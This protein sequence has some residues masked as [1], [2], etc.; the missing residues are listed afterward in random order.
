MLLGYAAGER[1]GAWRGIEPYSEIG[2]LDAAL[3][4]PLTRLVDALDHAWR[5]LREPATVEVWCER[6]RALK[7][8]FFAAD[9]GED[10]Y[11]LDRLD[12]ALE[13]WREACDEAALTQSLPLAIVA[14]NWLA[15]LEGGGLSQRFFAGAVTFAT[16]MPMRA[17][18]FRRVCLLGMNDGDYP[19]SRTPLDFDLMRRDYRPGDRSRREDDRYLFLE[20]LLS[21]RDHLH[22]SWVGRSVTDNTPRPPS[23]LVGQLRDHLKAGWRLEGEEEGG[24]EAL[25]H[26]L[27]IEH[28]LQPFSPDYFPARPDEALLYTYAHEW[29][30][31]APPPTDGAR[32]AALAPAERDE[33]LTI[34]ELGEFL[35]EP[36]RGFFRQRLR[37]AF[38]S[39]D[40]ASENHEPFEVDALQAWQLQGELIRAQVLAMERG[41]DDLEPVALA[42]LERMHRSGDLATGGFGEVIGEELLA[43]MP[44]LFAEYR[45]A[46]ARWP[47]PLEHQYEIRLDATR[48]G[49][50]VS[51]DDWLDDLRSGPDGALGRVIL[52]PGTLVK[53]S[54][55]RGDRLVPY[56]VA[57]VAAQLAA[58]PVTTVI[59][60]KVGVAE[61]APLDAQLA[62]DYLLAL[63]AAWD[64]GARRPL[65][66]AVKTAFAWLRKLPDAF[67]G[68]RATVPAEAWE[69]GLAAYEGNGRTPGERDTNAYLRR[70]FPDFEALA[71]HD[72]FITFATTLLLP[73]ARAPLASSRAKR[74]SGEAGDTA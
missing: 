5:T 54:R 21:A 49:R 34:R 51:L 43:P 14:E 59:V 42:C 4:G 30:R 23:V 63:L 50:V 64:D 57:H 73:V 56:W 35:R 52:E 48:D 45:K 1:A 71:A 38:E 53:D 33:P 67:D 65:P 13:T 36:V 37:V 74:A 47:E 32:A 6:L 62:R 55:Y 22:V 41:E 19:R 39:A 11:T 3:L 20:A 58:G 9:D 7:A 68:A 25:L 31:P 40:A 15:V 44:E 70:A 12:G 66:L 46:L 69:A 8:T 2:G 16:L 61:F 28:R 18:P 10:A 60:S 24:G 29:G 17:I 72:D 26:A 27:T